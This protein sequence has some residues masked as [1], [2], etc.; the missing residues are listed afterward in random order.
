LPLPGAVLPL[1]GAVL[2]LPTDVVI[3]QYRP[4]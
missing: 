3:E 4:A 1:S 2:P